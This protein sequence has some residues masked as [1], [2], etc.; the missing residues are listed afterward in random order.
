MIIYQKKNQYLL[1]YHEQGVLE[2]KK[3][4]LI[5]IID[6]YQLKNYARSALIQ[7]VKP[8]IID[9]RLVLMKA[10][11]Y[12]VLQKQQTEIEN[13]S[14]TTL[15]VHIAPV[16]PRCEICAKHLWKCQKHSMKLQLISFCGFCSNRILHYFPMCVSQSVSHRSDI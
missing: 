4:L 14:K 7:K 13:H 10:I 8:P 12:N 15:S 3:K 5:I 11:V 1:I 16:V 2:E 9:C 6:Y